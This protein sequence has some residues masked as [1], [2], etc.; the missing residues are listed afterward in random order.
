LSHLHG[1]A[2]ISIVMCVTCVEE[3]CENI[4]VVAARIFAFFTQHFPIQLYV[5]CGLSNDCGCTVF[6]A[7][8][9]IDSLYMGEFSVS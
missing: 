9:S 6:K 8:S 2:R 4:L 7:V 5:W 1:E 3:E